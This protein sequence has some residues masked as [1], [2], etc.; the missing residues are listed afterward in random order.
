VKNLSAWDRD[1]AHLLCA[2]VLVFALVRGTRHHGGSGS[3]AWFA[4]PL[5]LF[6]SW[7][8]TVLSFC[9]QRWVR[10]QVHG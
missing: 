10:A 8:L 5:L 3:G 7:N 9:V 6:L 2:C 4:V 1:V